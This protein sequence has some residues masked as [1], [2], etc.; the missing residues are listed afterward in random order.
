[1]RILVI[2]LT[3]KS[4]KNPASAIGVQKT[5]NDQVRMVA[6]RPSFSPYLKARN[7]K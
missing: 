6:E 3:G 2:S 4:S 7:I 5:K 1:M